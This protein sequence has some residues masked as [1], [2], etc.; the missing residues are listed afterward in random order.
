M[1]SC[2]IYDRDSWDDYCPECAAAYDPVSGGIYR[3]PEECLAVGGHEWVREV[4]CECCCHCGTIKNDRV[5]KEMAWQKNFSVRRHLSYIPREYIAGKVAL[6]GGTKQKNGESQTVT[7]RPEVLESIKGCKTWKDVFDLMR[8]R[9][10]QDYMLAVPHLMGHP[11]HVDSK[12]SEFA[13]ML[14]YSRRTGKTKLKW[15]YIIIKIFQ[16]SGEDWRWLPFKVTACTHR[17]NEKKWKA[18]CKQHGFEFMPIK[19]KD[20]VTPFA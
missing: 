10:C 11:V 17:K 3:T 16:L 13:T 2:Y 8:V 4:D 19:F 15:I 14:I 7:V 18:I 1:C 5:E 12:D 20:L 9:D 6:L